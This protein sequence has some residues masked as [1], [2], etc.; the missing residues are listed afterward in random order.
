M[1]GRPVNVR[2]NNALHCN[3]TQVRSTLLLNY[4][5]L[6]WSSLPLVNVNVAINLF[7]KKMK[8]AHQLILSC[9]S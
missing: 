1:N 9:D 2:H 8:K 4:Q 5:F 7:F 6:Q 3:V